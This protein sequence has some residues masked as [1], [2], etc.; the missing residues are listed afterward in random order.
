MA[1]YHGRFGRVAFTLTGA[2]LWALTGIP[3]EAASIPVATNLVAHGPN[4]VQNPGTSLTYSATAQGHGGTIEYQFWEQTASGWKVVQ[5][6][7]PQNSFTIHNAAA[8][9]YP[10]AVYALTAQQIKAGDWSQAVHQQFVA[11][12]G[13]QVILTASSSSISTNEPLTLTAQALH[14][15]NP[16]YQFWYKTPR[17]QWVGSNY[18]TSPTFTFHP[19]QPGTYD[20][21]VYAKDPVAPDTAE[22]SVWNTAEVTASS[23]NSPPLSVGYGNF[24]LSGTTPGS[25]WY[26]MIHHYNQL[27]TIAPLW[28]KAHRTGSLTQTASQTQITTVVNQAATEHL[29]VWPTIRMN[30]PLPQGWANTE[31]A[32]QLIKELTQ[33]AQSNH[34]QGYTLDFESLNTTGGSTLVTFVSNLAQALHAQ[35]Q[36]LMVDVLPLPDSRYPYAELAQYANYLNILA[37]PEYTTGSPSLTAPNP[38]PTEGLPWVK[39]AISA[40]LKVVPARQLLLGIAPYGQS[41]TYTNQGFQS[42]LAIPDRTIEENLAHQAGQWVFDPVQG[43]LQI[44]TGSTATAPSAPLSANSSSNPAVQNLQN[45]LN[46]VLLRYALSHNLTPPALLA[47]SGIVGHNTTQAIQ[48]F[49]E[50]FHVPGAT[51]GVYGPSTA[52]SLQQVIQQENI[53]DTVSWDENSEAAGILIQAAIAARFRGISIWRLGYQSPSLWD[54]LKANL[55]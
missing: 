15:I 3:I 2:A 24:S 21:V 30:K 36:K 41:W 33:T 46:V 44:S 6:Y 29:A 40:A 18:G 7:S 42:G 49:Q 53:G 43:E 13:S 9:S 37:Y 26:D 54:V 39:A 38:G 25:S 34:Y 23:P 14:L 55:N 1:S 47:T 17:G 45:I 10:V 48:A 20:L 28:Y 32:T 19:K 27:T 35:N 50:D 11:N 22:F 4:G 8:G 51:L 12:V 5:N 16:V 31:E 52:Q